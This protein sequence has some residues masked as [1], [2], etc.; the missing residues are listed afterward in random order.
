MQCRDRAGILIEE[1]YFAI[2]EGIP[3]VYT[4]G[5]RH[6]DDPMAGRLYRIDFDLQLSEHINTA[7]W[8]IDQDVCDGITLWSL[9]HRVCSWKSNPQEYRSLADLLTWAANHVCKKEIAK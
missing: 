6:P 2:S 3:V 1:Q 5:P 9:Q 7:D 4:V 8:T